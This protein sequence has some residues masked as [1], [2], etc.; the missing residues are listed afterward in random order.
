[1]FKRILASKKAIFHEES[2]RFMLFTGLKVMFVSLVITIILFY[3]L[4]LI[5]SINSAFFEASNYKGVDALRE[6]YMDFITSELFEVIPLASIFFFFLF[7]SGVY[8]GKLLLRPF[9]IIGD[10]C[11]KVIEDKNIPY[12]PDQFSD[13]KLLTRFSDFFFTYLLECREEGYLK[14]NTIPSQFTKIRKPQFDKIFFFHFLLY[15]LIICAVSSVILSNVATSIYLKIVEL[16]LAHIS[17]QSMSINH[18]VSS[19]TDIIDTIIT[20]TIALQAVC[21]TFLSY[22]LYAKVSGASFG[23]FATMKSFMK[24][25]YD[26]RVHLIGYNHIRPFSRAFNQYL[27]FIAEN[28][29]DRKVLKTKKIGPIS[30][31]NND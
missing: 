22:H 5:V 1:M 31:A 28:F 3:L 23:F 21:Y 29:A 4:W 7:F 14:T 19:Q 27:D 24:G 18:F 6:A 9:S 12:E 30:L 20:S 26:S 15:I 11:Q 2:T 8:L 10:Y 25:N 17:S 16:A 13:F